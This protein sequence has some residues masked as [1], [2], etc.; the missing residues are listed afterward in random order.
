MGKRKIHNPL[1]Q[2]SFGEMVGIR[3]PERARRLSIPAPM[4]QTAELICAA[5]KADWVRFKPTIQNGRWKIGISTHKG[6]CRSENQDYALGFQ[7]RG[8]DVVV[9]ADG[10]GGMPHGQMASYLACLSAAVS[11]MHTYGTRRWRRAQKPQHAIAKAFDDAVHRLATEAD[12]LNVSTLSDG[13]RTTLIVMLASPE[14]LSYGF[15]GDGGGCVVREEGRNEHFLLPQRENHAALNI[16]AASLGPAMQ[17]QPVIGS[18]EKSPGDLVVAGTDG[19][20]DRVNEE[21]P[22]D[23]LRGCLLFDG[24]LQAVAENVLDELAFFKD[25]LGYIC[26]DNMTLAILGGGEVPRGPAGLMSVHSG[27][28]GKITDF[29]TTQNGTPQKPKVPPRE[30]A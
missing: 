17:G 23:I 25:G 18:M 26:D 8:M 7:I 11:L 9:I 3:P 20:F 2:S 22:Q 14:E 5:E 1:I 27:I 19:V 30:D 13:L 10:C 4:E 12:K 6:N 24:Y 15:I 29:E 28:S 21:F 16:L